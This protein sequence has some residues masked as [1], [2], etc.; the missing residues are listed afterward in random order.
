MLVCVCVMS[1][2]VCLC[3]HELGASVYVCA[4]VHT[5]ICL[6]VCV[7]VFCLCMFVYV[8]V[9]LCVCLCVYLYIITNLTGIGI[10]DWTLDQGNLVTSLEFFFQ[11]NAYHPFSQCSHP[12][13]HSDPVLLT[14]ILPKS[15]KTTISDR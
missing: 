1:V 5:C 14:E 8:C 6:F 15:V 12:Q 10:L 4:F 2:Y 3:V 9:C 7:C 11:R 13:K